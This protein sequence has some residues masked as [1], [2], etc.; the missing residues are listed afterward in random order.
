[1]A[2]GFEVDHSG[3]CCLDCPFTSWAGFAKGHAVEVAWDFGAQGFAD[4]CWVAF[5]FA[6]VALDVFDVA[7]DDDVRF[8]RFPREGGEDFFGCI[9]RH[10]IDGSIIA[11][12]RLFTGRYERFCPIISCV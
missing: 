1:M 3:C 9:L 11:L 5:G 12:T 2:W 10:S 7:Y 4:G 8:E 6:V